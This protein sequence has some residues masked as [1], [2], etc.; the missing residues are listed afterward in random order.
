MQ[1]GNQNAQFD[2]FGISDAPK[3]A[4]H[5]GQTGSMLPAVKV[6]AFED[7][8]DEDATTPLA[9][10]GGKPAHKLVKVR[11]APHAVS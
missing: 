1:G 3:A 10:G 9:A 6:D 4:G 2:P 7:E 5:D 11:L 8:F